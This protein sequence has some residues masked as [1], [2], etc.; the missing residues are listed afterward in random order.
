MSFYDFASPGGEAV[1]A[2]TAGLLQRE[3]LKRQAMLDELN[4]QNIQ[5]QMADRESNR[6][7][8]DE[9]AKSLAAEREAAAADR[10][11]KEVAGVIQTLKPGQDI[12]GTSAAGLVP[13]YLQHTEGGATL[14]STQ[15]AQALVP[16][17]TA[18]T[19][20]GSVT[21]KSES[22]PDASVP[23]RQV[24][25][26]TPQQVGMK[27]L[28]DEMRQATEGGK[29]LNRDQI[30]QR[31]IDVGVPIDKVGEGVDH[32]FKG[33][34]QAHAYV[35]DANGKV[36][37]TLDIQGDKD[38]V[39]GLPKPNDPTAAGNRQDT[40]LDRSYQY[41][42][43][44]LEK[45]ALPLEQASQRLERLKVSIAQ[46]DPQADSLIAPELLT[47]M[48]GGQGS[49]LRMNEAEI[50]RIVNGRS[51]WDTIRAALNK[52]KPGDAALSIPDNQRQNMY[53][54]V[55]EVSSRLDNH[56]HQLDQA[57]SDLIQAN[58]VTEH[59]RIL[60][61]VKQSLNSSTDATGAGSTPATSAKKNPTDPNWGS[62]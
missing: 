55:G 36:V 5:S 9:N 46:K 32:L 21:T 58:D 13:G 22:Q 61:R 4:R 28:S 35:L 19:S 1:D 45:A 26:G 39:H 18:P 16:G 56:L 33:Q 52:W 37:N 20:G 7:I 10:K 29:P 2:M 59:R 30:A 49:G 44:L 47:V 48:A 24:Y 60:A 53:K 42:S 23:T 15:F 54:L 62:K 40:R 57:R 43:G 25:T 38:M 8:Q 11:Q 27:N 50:S 31:L 17:E 14:P 34:G 3:Q 51:N 12:T 41:N 6:R